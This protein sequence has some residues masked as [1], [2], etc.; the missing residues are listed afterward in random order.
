MARDDIGDYR[1]TD[2]DQRIRAIATGVVTAAINDIRP[3]LDGVPLL[4]AQLE[5]IL[6]RLEALSPN[7]NKGTQNVDEFFSWIDEVETGF[8]VMDCSED[9]KLKVVANK[10]KGSAVAY[11]KYLKNK[12][13]LDG[14][15]T[16][17]NVGEDEE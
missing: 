6:Q 9:R 17:C 10:L 3:L 1:S 5:E 16:D 15:T 11:W 4:Q 12:R 7:G 14:K 13:V 2:K 8:G